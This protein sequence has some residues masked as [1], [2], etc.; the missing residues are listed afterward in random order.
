MKPRSFHLQLGRLTKL[1]SV[2]SLFVSFHAFAGTR[3]GASGGGVALGSSVIEVRRAAIDTQSSLKNKDLFL[4]A[5]NTAHPLN[6]QN[7]SDPIAKKVME[8]I[9]AAQEKYFSFGQIQFLEKGSCESSNETDRDMK[10]N[11]K[12][13]SDICFSI[14]RMQRYSAMSLESEILPLLLH[15][16][17]HQLGI[18]EREAVALQLA[19]HAKLGSVILARTFASF[20]IGETSFGKR[21]FLGAS[22]AG[23]AK[24]L[25][26]INPEEERRFR[27]KLEEVCF[28]PTAAEQDKNKVNHLI[29]ALINKKGEEVFRV[30]AQSCALQ[31]IIV[32]AKTVVMDQ[33]SDKT[34]SS[35]RGAYGVRLILQRSKV[36]HITDSLGNAVDYFS[37]LPMHGFVETGL[38]DPNSAPAGSLI[39]FSGPQSDQYLKTGV[40]SS[41]LGNGNWAGSVTIKGDDGFYYLDGRTRE[42]ALGWNEGQNTKNLRNVMGIFVPGALLIEE[43]KDLCPG[44]NFSQN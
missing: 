13:G 4:A 41:H 10:T 15:E 43:N 23:Q 26:M 1:L 22:L 28:G 39:V 7:I 27:G 33:F 24:T 38:R 3:D 44:Q 37:H 42:P 16:Y 17:A 6:P 8:K 34:Y 31:K 20:D 40:P 5:E 25:N 9:L 30:L 2:A 32:S 36:G 11:F 35:G 29:D 12:E 21:C 14:E 19:V 18:G